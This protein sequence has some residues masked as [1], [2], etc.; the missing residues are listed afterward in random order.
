MKRIAVVTTLLLATTAAAHADRKA[1]DGCA[2]GLAPDART[3]YDLTIDDVGP[4]TKLKDVVIAK[5][6]PMVLSGKLGRDA[7]KT[8]AM[9]AGKCLVLAK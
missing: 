9:A 2:G 3:I 4:G 1:A 7:A 6:R 5:V 8:A